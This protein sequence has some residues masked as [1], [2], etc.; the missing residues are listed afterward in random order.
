MG[1]NYYLVSPECSHCGKELEPRIHLGKSSF[2][3]CFSLHVYPEFGICDIAAIRALIVEKI[4][5]KWYIINEYNEQISV[6]KFFDIV[7]K[8][9]GKQISEENLEWYKQNYA[10]PGPKNL[11]RHQLHPNHCIGH[12]TG[13]YDYC[14]GEFS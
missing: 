13:T 12:G 8:R 10:L 1:T 9:K 3:W 6:D 14:I 11:V 7:T 4:K 2:G 5:D